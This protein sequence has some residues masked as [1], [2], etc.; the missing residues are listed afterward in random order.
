MHLIRQYWL[1]S[2]FT[3]EDKGGGEGG[4]YVIVVYMYIYIYICNKVLQVVV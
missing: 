1:Q 4:G 2:P 3:W